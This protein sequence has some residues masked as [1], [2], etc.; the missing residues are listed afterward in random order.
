MEFQKLTPKND[1]NLN[2]YEEAFN[3]VF[4][5]DDI[6]NVAISGAYSSGK[7]SVLESYKIKHTEKRFLHIS[8]THFTTL[9]E[10]NQLEE[11]LSNNKVSESILEGKILNQLIH[12]IPINKIPQ[13]SFKAKQTIKSKDIMSLA[14]WVILFALCVAILFFAPGISEFAQELNDNCVKKILTFLFCPYARIISGIIRTFCSVRFIYKLIEGQKLKTLFRKISFQ[15]N[16]IEI[17]EKQDD[18]Y[19][20]KYLNEVLYLFENVDDDV[21]VFEDID[22]F[23]EN[24]VFEH[25]REINNIVNTNRKKPLRF[26]YLIRD[27]IFTSKDRTKFF[28]FIIPI[29]PVIDGSNSY[30][31]LVIFLGENVVNYNLDKSFLQKLSLYIDDMRLLKNI[32]NEFTLYINILNTTDLNPNKMMSMITYKNLFPRDFSDLQ[33]A[34]GFVHELFSYKSFL[35]EETLKKYDVNRLELSDRIEWAKKETPILQ[36]ELEDAYKIKNQRLSDKYKYEHGMESQKKYTTIQNQYKEDKAKRTQAVQDNLDNRLP[37]LEA[38]L[39]QINYDIE[40]IQS[41]ALSELITRENVDNVFAREHKNKLGETNHFKEIKRSEYFDLLKFLIWNGYIDETYSDY[42]S[43]FYPGSI[44]ANDKIFLRRITDKRGHDYTYRINDPQA[45][46]ESPLMSVADFREDEVLNFCLFEYLLSNNDS[47]K[48]AK[49]LQTF[50]SQLKEKRNFDFISRYYA[51]DNTRGKFVRIFNQQWP[52][53]FSS[54]LCDNSISLDL[55]RRYSIDTLY[56]SDLSDIEKIN[57]DDCLSEYISQKSDY[58]S[59]V[60]PDVDKLISCF[61]DIGVSFAQ[62]D[63]EV[64]NQQLFDEVYEN[65]L[66]EINFENI[67]LLLKIKYGI[68]NDFNIIHKNYTQILSNTGS[69]LHN[70][71]SENLMQYLAVILDN[72]EDRISD[73]ENIVLDVL[74]HQEIEDTLKI[75][76]IGFLAT[77]ISDITLVTNNALWKYILQRK[78]LCFSPGNCLNYFIKNRLDS[79]LI[80]YINESPQETSFS[81]VLD[82]FDDD[83]V[84]SFCETIVKCNDI[85]TDKYKMILCNLDYE[86]AAYDVQSIEDEKIEVLIDS[87][88]M[89]MTT[90]SIEYIRTNYPETKYSFIKQN[91]SSYIEIQDEIAEP[92]EILTIINWDID[93]AHKLNLLKF[94]DEPISIIDRDYSDEVAAYILTNNYEQS[95]MAEL[96]NNFSIYGEQTKRIIFELTICYIESIAANMFELDDKLLSL[97]LKDKTVTMDQKLE[98]F[99]LSLSKMDEEQCM[100]HLEE[101]DLAELNNIFSKNSGRRRYENNEETTAIFNTLK[102]HGWIADFYE[103]EKNPQKYVVKKNKNQ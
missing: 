31:Q 4:K 56:Y 64:S 49:Y 53:F 50:I 7:S 89:Q 81:N 38:K 73:D 99:D 36:E 20:D 60:H 18:S 35:I 22:R 68:E 77:I 29:I 13:T 8:L 86:F 88:L 75:R 92:E 19:F 96:L 102:K 79:E 54:A 85:S 43:Y 58:L 65:D 100:L 87:G 61:K 11:S 48:I 1:V 63:F 97:L 37:E 30:E 28:D 78:A 98:L 72:C 66:Y 25:L 17:F 34:R 82:E 5:N 32:C 90:D 39:A 83:F 74:N 57:L 40:T 15:G 84:Q 101:L 55:I 41:K 10:E 76:Y 103:D 93:N 33:L 27:D 16:E 70:Y 9:D 14:I 24:Q 59:I 46:V 95:D 45:I 12:H 23:N 94:V 26:F 67:R 69:P 80:E 71:I 52:E 51:I 44:S 3:F 2:G 47:E 62:I 42:M 21:I 6:R 91:F